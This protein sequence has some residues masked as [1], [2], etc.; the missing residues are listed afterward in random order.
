MPTRGL[1]GAAPAPNQT[2]NRDE[3]GAPLRCIS[4]RRSSVSREP[5]N[6][7]ASLSARSR[8]HMRWRSASPGIPAATSQTKRKAWRPWSSSESD[9]SSGVPSEHKAALRSAPFGSANAKPDSSENENQELVAFAVG[10]KRLGQFAHEGDELRSGVRIFHE[11]RRRSTHSS[12]RFVV[13]ALRAQFGRDGEQRAFDLRLD[14]W[15]RTRAGIHAMQRARITLTGRRKEAGPATGVLVGPLA[16]P[17]LV[18]GSV[19]QQLSVLGYAADVVARIF[20]RDRTFVDRAVRV[21]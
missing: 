15:A 20:K 1:P 19:E 21:R 16:D 12:N 5:S 8:S 14:R 17:H 7:G 4:N 2:R 9:I 11:R 13:A 6:C 3:S 10:E 18:L